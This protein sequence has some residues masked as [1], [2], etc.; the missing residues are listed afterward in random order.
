MKPFQLAILG[1]VAFLVADH[2]L[3]EG[4]YREAAWVQVKLGADYLNTELAR[5]S[6]A[7]FGRPH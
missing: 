5:L 2:F 4:R 1:M 3:F 7:L 6:P